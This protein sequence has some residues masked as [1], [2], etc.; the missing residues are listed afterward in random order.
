MVHSGMSNH[1]STHARGGVAAVCRDAS[2]RLTCQTDSNGEHDMT[3]EVEVKLVADIRANESEGTVLRVQLGRRV[4]EHTTAGAKLLDLAT[5]LEYSKGALSMY[6]IV[7]REYGPELT[8]D[9]AKAWGDIRALYAWRP[10]QSGMPASEVLS[11]ARKREDA[12]S[13][14]RAKS[15]DAASTADSSSSTEVEATVGQVEAGTDSNGVSVRTV[16]IP[17]AVY[18]K[19][20]SRRQGTETVADVIARI[21]FGDFTEHLAKGV[22]QGNEPVRKSNRTVRTSKGKRVIPA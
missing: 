3:Y 6:Q 5:A 12:P 22:V 19:L 17:T 21:A 20:D 8:D 4:L 9:I 7:A 18:N 14:P 13:K 15:D 2:S 16:T 10:S 1:E 11:S